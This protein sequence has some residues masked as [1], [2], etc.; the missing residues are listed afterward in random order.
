MNEIYLEKYSISELLKFYTEIIEELINRRVLRTRN[1]PVA[2][3]TE[4]LV[5]SKLQF[6]LENNSKSGYDATDIKGIKY[7][8]KGRRITPT[9]KSKQLGVIRKLESKKFDY[10]I[11]LVFDKDFSL[12]EGYKIPHQTIK[13]YAKFS[14]HQNGHILHLKGEILRD[15][16]TENIINILK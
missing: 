2:D 4:W 11:G 14:K 7:Q 9:N 16:K 8:I 13:K 12:I 1:N 5:S 10:L 15:P 3:Y 6:K